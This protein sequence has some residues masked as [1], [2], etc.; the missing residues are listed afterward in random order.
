MQWKDIQ[1]LQAQIISA[2]CDSSP[3][4]VDYD[5]NRLDYLNKY[6]QSMIDQGMIKSGSYCLWRHGK[7]FADVAIGNLAYPWMGNTVFRPDTLFEIQSV[8][9]VI[10][11]IAILKLMEDGICYLGQPVKEWISEFDVEDF[12][13]ITI[14]HLLTHTSG[15]CALDGCFPED[16]RFWWKNMDENDSERTWISAVVKTG[17]H[18]KPGEKWI[19][20]IV[21]YFILGE[22]IKRATGMEAEEYMKENIF[23][24]CEM[25]DTH[26]RKYATID[27]IK[28]YNIANET[29]IAMVEKCK[30]HGDMAMAA[31]TYQCWRGIPDTAGG[32]MST[33][34]EMVHLGEMLLRDGYY[35]GKRVIGK[36]AL[37]LLWTDL[38]NANV[39]DVTHGRNKKLRYGAGVPIYSSKLD[40]EQLLSEGTI[41]HEGAGTSVFLVDREEDFAAMFQTSF[42]KE[43]DWDYRAVKGTASIIWSGVK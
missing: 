14:M 32:E 12:R 23:I 38:L 27:Q 20:S 1:Q 30:V 42:C 36:K 3:E 10:T 25:Y 33:C 13:D 29:D 5:A 18:A 11:A 7:I 4:E 39:L 22:I 37:S 6:I 31:P 24:P 2:E 21:A 41:F 8:G 16:E 15:I 17:L 40:M 26:W 35:K 28:R 34:R 19:Y 9:K 43:F